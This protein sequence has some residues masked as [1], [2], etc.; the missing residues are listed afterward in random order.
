VLEGLRSFAAYDA[1]RR[2]LLQEL[3]VRSAIPV[4]LSAGRA[5][6]EVDGPYSAAALQQAL[7]ES[8]GEGLRVVP[9]DQDGQTLTLLVDWTPP[10]PSPAPLADADPTPPD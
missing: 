10:P 5:V 4:E 6:L 2:T 3:E 1:L 8:V 9:L 7:L